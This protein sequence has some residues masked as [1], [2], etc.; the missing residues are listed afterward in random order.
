MC[1]GFLFFPKDEDFRRRGRRPYSGL[2]RDPCRSGR[3][4]RRRNPAIRW[5]RAI[6]TRRAGS[7]QGSSSSRVAGRSPAAQRNTHCRGQDYQSRDCSG[8]P[9][10]NPLWAGTS[11]FSEPDTHAREQG[12]RHRLIGDDAKMRING[13]KE[14]RLVRKGRA[15]T[16]AAMQMLTQLRRGFRLAG[17]Q[18]LDYFFLCT[19]AIHRNFSANLFL[20]ANNRDFT[21]PAGTP[22]S[23]A[24]S[25]MECPSMAD[26]N[27]TNRKRSGNSSRA[28]P[29]RS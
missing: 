10:R 20:A 18:R 7:N 27:I 24:T 3:R 12:R 17:G 11:I 29:S 5:P 15:A 19:L 9:V 23:A 6:R 2:R 22:M 28:R 4:C 25:S 14:G 1:K 8:P 21:V 16:G 13:L 26:N